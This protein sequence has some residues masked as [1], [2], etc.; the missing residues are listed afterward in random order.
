MTAP[1]CNTCNHFKRKRMAKKSQELEKMADIKF[2]CAEKY[3]SIVGKQGM[4]PKWKFFALGEEKREEPGKDR[5]MYHTHRMQH[6]I[7]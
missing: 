1:W 7:V 6:T 3:Q 5:I 4:V 2:I